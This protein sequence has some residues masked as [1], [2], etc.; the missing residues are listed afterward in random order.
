M[1][2]N[3]VITDTAIRSANVMVN[4]TI[5]IRPLV[6]DWFRT[7]AA[8]NQ[9]NVSQEIRR[10]LEL[11]YKYRDAIREAENATPRFVREVRRD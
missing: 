8:R 9:T 4:K 2:R 1:T 10:W 5:K 3:S 7:E 11:A 6:L